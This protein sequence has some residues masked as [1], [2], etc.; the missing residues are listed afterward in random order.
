MSTFS[1]H[2][3]SRHDLQKALLPK[4]L[5]EP[6]SIFY[7]V[8]VH[9]ITKTIATVGAL[10]YKEVKTLKTDSGGKKV[11]P[12]KRCNHSP[13]RGLRYQFC[14]NTLAVSCFVLLNPSKPGLM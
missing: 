8:G 3:Y 11:N 5:G 1:P 7:I 13:I 4:S 2:R 14:Y 10:N 9:I 12:K 6:A